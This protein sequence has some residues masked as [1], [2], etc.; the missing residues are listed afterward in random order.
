MAAPKLKEGE[1][2]VTV[3]L[4]ANLSRLVR[5]AAELDR[6]SHAEIIRRALVAWF[7]SDDYKAL[8]TSGTAQRR[9]MTF[10]AE[11]I[12]PAPKKDEPQ[13]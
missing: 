5:E 6:R 10:M 12:V 8:V 7:A 2:Y 1:R 9:S 4:D 13:K 3:L 11:V